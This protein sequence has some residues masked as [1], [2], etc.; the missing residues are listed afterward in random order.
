MAKPDQDNLQIM[1]FSA[2]N[3]FP[4]WQADISGPKP[5]LP[6]SSLCNSM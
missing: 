4:C 3:S 5:T 2:L 6:N 1:K